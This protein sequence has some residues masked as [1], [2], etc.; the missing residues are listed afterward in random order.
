VSRQREEQ[1][2]LKPGAR[3]L[4]V[5]IREKRVLGVVEDDCRV[6]ARPEPIGKQR[7]ADADGALNCDVSEVQGA[8]S[9]PA[10]AAVL[11]R[12]VRRSIANARGRLR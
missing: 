10:A 1:L 5:K 2:G 11:V 12:A 3:T 7:F 4:A 6:E 8:C 9:V